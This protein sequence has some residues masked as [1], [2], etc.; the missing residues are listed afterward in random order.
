MHLK[1]KMQYNELFIILSQIY[2]GRFL[3][4]LKGKSSFD[5][6]NNKIIEEKDLI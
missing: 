6:K 4:F 1:K 2:F 5:E 3:A